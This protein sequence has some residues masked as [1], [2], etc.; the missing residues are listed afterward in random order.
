MDASISHLS[1]EA[2]VT[3]LPRL[4]YTVEEVAVILGIS[5]VSVRRLI[6]RGLLRPSRALR[7]L[8]IS[9]SEI[10]RF[11]E[12]TLAAEPSTDS[13]IRRTVSIR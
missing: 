5:T 7:V 1:K 2:P 3:T 12:T 13:F 6:R 11:L 4:A 9:K 8:L 10:E